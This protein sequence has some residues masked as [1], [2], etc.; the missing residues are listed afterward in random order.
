MAPTRRRED[1]P[2]TE[3]LQSEPEQFDFFQAVRLLERWA[4]EEAAE[5]GLERPP[6]VGSGASPSE[7]FV[8]F[9]A[10]PSL[11]FPAASIARIETPAGRDEPAPPFRREVTVNFLGLTGPVGVLPQHYTS[12]L[13][14]RLHSR[15]KDYTLRDFLDV[16][17]HRLTSLFFR[18]WEKYRFAFGY[19]RAHLEGSPREE[20]LF[21]SCL[22]SMVGLGTPGL[23]GRL[24]FDDEAVLYYGGHFAHFPRSAA[25]LEQLLGDYF[26]VPVEV[27]QFSG[28]W[29]HLGDEFQSRM[30]DARHPEGLNMELGRTAII[31]EWVW[32]VQS[33][34]RARVGPVRY[35]QFAEFMPCGSALLPFSQ[36]ARLHA[37][38]EFDFDVQ[39]VLMADEVPW[40]RLSPEGPAAPRLGWNT[41]IRTSEFEHDV[42]DAVFRL[43]SV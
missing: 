15:N 9:R 34:F 33:K 1:A 18:A 35:E 8:R 36:M 10:L 14:E 11:A 24:E 3:R 30:P 13:I 40:C 16:F 38:Q 28:Q 22:Y 29:L 2:L 4:R 12:L 42:E 31:G 23:R 27:E 43:E 37:G 25:A 5:R 21:T 19:D 20:D 39:V 6:P 26:G 41:W 7:D 17:H 32:D